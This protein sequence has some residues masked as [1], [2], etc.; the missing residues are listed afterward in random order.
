L[1]DN[2]CFFYDTGIV[3]EINGTQLLILDTDTSKIR[4][5]PLEALSSIRLNASDGALLQL[6][7]QS[8]ANVKSF[9]FQNVQIRQQVVDKL[10][11]SVPRLFR[12]VSKN[13]KP[14]FFI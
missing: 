4:V 14:S 2:F 10:Y 13:P 7:F 3:F 1:C 8:S 6:E 12:Q 5:Y 9:R 11:A